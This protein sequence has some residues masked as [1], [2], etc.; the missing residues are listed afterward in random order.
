MMRKQYEYRMC[1]VNVFGVA[2][3]QKLN[4]LSFN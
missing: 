1:V 2:L 3:Q 4:D